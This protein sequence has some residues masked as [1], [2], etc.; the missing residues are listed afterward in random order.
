MEGWIQFSLRCFYVKHFFFKIVIIYCFLCFVGF[1]PVSCVPNVASVSGLSLVGFFLIP[2]RF[3]LNVY[4]HR[5]DR[6]NISLKW[7]V[8]LLCCIN[9]FANPL[10]FFS[11]QNSCW[12]LVIFLDSNCRHLNQI[13][14]TISFYQ[15]EKEIKWIL[16]TS[17]PTTGYLD[18]RCYRELRSYLRHTEWQVGISLTFFFH[19]IY[20]LD[21]KFMSDLLHYKWEICIPNM[22]V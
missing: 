9:R 16:D 5:Q 14:F 12:T 4:L 6:S 15:W 7:F 2:L 11:C 8:K 20:F 10:G 13:N 19:F 22:T 1:R 3:S 17:H 18:N 21:S